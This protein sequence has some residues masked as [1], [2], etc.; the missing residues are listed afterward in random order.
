MFDMLVQNNDTDYNTISNIWPISVLTLSECLC[1]ED[2]PCS[3]FY[4][5]YMLD[6]SLLIQVEVIHWEHVSVTQGSNII[7]MD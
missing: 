7:H 2:S 5:T 6:C 4:Y 3:K 1:K